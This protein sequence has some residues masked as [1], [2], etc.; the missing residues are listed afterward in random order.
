MDGQ[1]GHQ[2]RSTE[3]IL[4]SGDLPVPVHEQGIIALVAGFHGGSTRSR[5]TGFWLLLSPADQKRVR[6]LAALLRVADGL[7]YLHA[8]SVTDLHCTI[9]GTEVQCV[10]TCTGD[11]ATEKARAI[12]KSDLF[13]DVFGKTLVIP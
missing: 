13:A 7:D 3:L 2:K 9:G 6:I 10:I 12:K 1:A 5:P 4:T 8:A 11:A